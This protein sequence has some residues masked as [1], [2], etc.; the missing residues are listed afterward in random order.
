MYYGL[1]CTLAKFSAGRFFEEEMM[2]KLATVFVSAGV[3]ALFS[4]VAQAGLVD[5]SLDCNFPGD[6]YMYRHEWSVN[7]GLAELTIV[8]TFDELGPDVAELSGETDSDLTSFTVIGRATN[9]TATT[10]TGYTLTLYDLVSKA[11]FVNGSAGAV[12]SKLQTVA[13]L[14]STT[15]EFSGDDPVLD[16]HLLQFQF[17]I[18]VPTAGAFELTLTQNPIP[19]PA[20]I[21]LLGLGSLALLRRRKR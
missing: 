15:I 16:G 11:T 9:S 20:T 2:N 10:W 6:P 8:Q 12:G 1:F 14:D 13:Y 4:T 5:S 19:E 17:D 7:Y 21:A 18:L 3:I